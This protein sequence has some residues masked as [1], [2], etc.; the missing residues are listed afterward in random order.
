MGDNYSDIFT[1]KST[2]IC[3]SISTSFL[4]TGVF[5]LSIE[6]G[7]LGGGLSYVCIFIY[8]GFILQVPSVLSKRNS[9]LLDI[10]QSIK[11]S[12][13]DKCLIYDATLCRLY[14]LQ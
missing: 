8:T 9:C 5:S 11:I 13:Y 7:L 10:L 3:Q 6:C 12:S 4:K 1:F 2:P 14:F